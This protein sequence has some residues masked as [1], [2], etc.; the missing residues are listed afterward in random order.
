[1]SE[2]KTQNLNTNS[3]LPSITTVTLVQQ[4]NNLNHFLLTVN[5]N[6]SILGQ[7]IHINDID[8]NGLIYNIVS[9][10]NPNT[11]INEYS[12]TQ[13]VDDTKLKKEINDTF[14]VYDNVSLSD[15]GKSIPFKGTVQGTGDG[16]DK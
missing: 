11:T 15:I 13:M 14:C 4:Q 3:V 16:D 7:Q 8:D 10:V 1:M 6:S 5:F 12:L 2:T 9:G